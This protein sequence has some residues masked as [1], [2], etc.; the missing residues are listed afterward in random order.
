MEIL[1]INLDAADEVLEESENAVCIEK[2]VYGIRWED[3]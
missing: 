2:I 3:A 1:N